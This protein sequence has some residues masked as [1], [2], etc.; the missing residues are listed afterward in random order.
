M[1]WAGVAGHLAE[2]PADLGHAGAQLGVTDLD[3]HHRVL[4]ARQRAVGALH[5]RDRLVQE[6][7]DAMRRRARGWGGE[8]VAGE[9]APS[10]TPM[11]SVAPD[12]AP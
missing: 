9:V 2:L 12:D 5:R 1:S 3:G 7:L 11:S 8:G 10:A 6:A 4:E